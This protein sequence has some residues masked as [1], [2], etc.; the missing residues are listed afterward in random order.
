MRFELKLPELWPWEG[1]KPKLGKCPKWICSCKTF[2]YFLALFYK[3]NSK[4]VMKNYLSQDWFTCFIVGVMK[5]ICDPWPFSDLRICGRH[6]CFGPTLQ[7]SA[8]IH[9]N[10]QRFKCWFLF[11]NPKAEKVKLEKLQDHFQDWH[12]L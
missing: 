5:Y 7:H 9:I 8:L 10:C 12:F 11:F 6:Q 2:F 4:I 1:A 3:S